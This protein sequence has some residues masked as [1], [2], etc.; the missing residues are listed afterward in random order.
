MLYR[1]GGGGG[2]VGVG[3]VGHYTKDFKTQQP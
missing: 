1:G 3:G 2:G